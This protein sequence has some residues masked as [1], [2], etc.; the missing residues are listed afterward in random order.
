[1]R[2]FDVLTEH[3][4]I[5]EEK[6][7]VYLEKTDENEP[8]LRVNCV[9]SSGAMFNRSVEEPPSQSFTEQLYHPVN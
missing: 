5:V 8:H 4:E 1:M 3:L 6:T 9:I 7:K 2:T